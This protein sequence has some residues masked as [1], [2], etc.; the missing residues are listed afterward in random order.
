MK[1]DTTK[2]F[3]II[4]TSIVGILLILGIFNIVKVYKVDN[5]SIVVSKRAFERELSDTVDIAGDKVLPGDKVILNYNGDLKIGRITEINKE[6]NK[7][8]V[9]I[10]SEKYPVEILSPKETMY[11]LVPDY[12]VKLK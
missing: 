6:K 2:I 8:Y 3:S 1:K 9:E 4:I 5:E 11:L 10:N 7:L 12:Y